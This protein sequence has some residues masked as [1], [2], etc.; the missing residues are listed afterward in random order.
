MALGLIDRSA[1]LGR[2]PEVQDDVDIQLD[3]GG[4]APPPVVP[5]AVPPPVE[6]PGAEPP[7]AIDGREAYRASHPN[8]EF[9]GALPDGGPPPMPVPQVPPPPVS[10]Q[11]GGAGGGVGASSFARPGSAAARPF[12]SSQFASSRAQGGGPGEARFGAG[13]PIVGGAAAPISDFG[14]GAGGGDIPEDELAQ[15][16]AQVAGRYTG[17]Q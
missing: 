11:L 17:G 2:E 9:G 4:A 15:I 3:R 12:R 7:P 5:E 10:F 14:G 8:L 1:A 16:M 13:S 6:A